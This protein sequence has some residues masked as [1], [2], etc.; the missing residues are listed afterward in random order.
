MSR[1]TPELIADAA[2]ATIVMSEMDFG[3]LDGQFEYAVCNFGTGMENPTDGD[4]AEWVAGGGLF[5]YKVTCLG[6]G[7]YVAGTF[8]PNIPVYHWYAEQTPRPE[9][10]S[11]QK[12][13]FKVNTIGGSVEVLDTNG[14]Y[15]PANFFEVNE[16]VNMGIDLGAESVAFRA[17]PSVNHLLAGQLEPILKPDSPE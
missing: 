5:D 7:G 1:P 9:N 12:I 13:E 16:L 3:F 17:G 6:F 15:R 8:T 14:G 2:E 4:Y 11:G 10:P